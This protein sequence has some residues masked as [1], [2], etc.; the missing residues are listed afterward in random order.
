MTRV[1]YVCAD[2]GVPVFGS[3][4]CSIHVQEV[5]RALRRRGMSVELH[6]TRRGGEPPA[7]LAD[8]PVF[9]LPRPRGNGGERELSAHAANAATQRSL[10]ARPRYAFVYERHSLW[11]RAA[12]E[13]ARAE[14]LPGVLEVNAPLVEE[15]AAHR[16]L[17]HRA[18]ALE[19]ARRSFDAASLRVAVTSAVADYVRGISPGPVAVVPNGVDPGRFAPGPARRRAAGDP[20]TVGFVGTL[21]P[22]HGLPHLVEAFARLQR[23]RP[24]ARLLVVGDGPGRAAF[25]GALAQHGLLE[26]TSRVG[27]VPPAEVPGWL[28]RMHAGVAPYPRLDDFYFSPLKVLEYMAAGIPTVASDIGEI[29]RW[30]EHGRH[31]LL[32]PPGDARALA[33]ALEQLV[34]EP[35]AAAELGRHARARAA[36]RHSWDAVVGEILERAR[37]PVTAA[38]P[39][40]RTP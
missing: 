25:E 35:E 9:P 18:L 24:Q 10:E 2:P 31:G 34:D 37:G 21:K 1:A 12:M 23:S 38:A 6:A 22:W 33:D 27:A 19:T 16:G 28:A 36:E 11:S 8:L 39:E 14:R 7:D 29:P 30:I 32:C 4:G 20:F 5:V 15:Q 40:A 13:F 3:K 26:R 17:D